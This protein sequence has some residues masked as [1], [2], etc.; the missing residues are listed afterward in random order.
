M[1]SFYNDKYDDGSEF[2]VIKSLT[3]FEDADN[4]LNPKMMSNNFSWK[5]VK[6]Q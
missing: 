1:I 2:M 5:N 3:Y 6:K 4:Q